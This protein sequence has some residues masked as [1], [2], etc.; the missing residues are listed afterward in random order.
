VKVWYVLEKYFMLYTLYLP[1]CLLFV[2]QA[3]SVETGH[4][5]KAGDEEEDDEESLDWWSRFVCLQ[6]VAREMPYFIFLQKNPS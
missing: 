1:F 5:K 6:S 3:K 2:L 4:S